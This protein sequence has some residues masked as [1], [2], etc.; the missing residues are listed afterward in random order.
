MITMKVEQ[1]SVA[2]DHH[3]IRLT[4]FSAG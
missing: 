1:L 3:K 2:Y 4:F